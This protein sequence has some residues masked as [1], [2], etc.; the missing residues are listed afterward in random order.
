MGHETAPGYILCAARTSNG[1]A[2]GCCRR[3][4]RV[5]DRCWQHGGRRVHPLVVRFL[6]GE[7]VLVL[8]RELSPEKSRR[9]RAAYVETLIREHIRGKR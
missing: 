6:A 1:S 2:L 8:A 7:D 4:W 5:R 3:V 9:E